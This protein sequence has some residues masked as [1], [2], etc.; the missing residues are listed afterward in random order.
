[1][2]MLNLS[3]LVLGCSLPL[4]AAL[5]EPQVLSF[6][7]SS[8]WDVRETSQRPWQSVDSDGYIISSR[9]RNH[10]LPLLLDSKDNVAIHIAARTFANDVYRVTGVRPEMYND[11]LPN[12]TR[13]AI[14]IGT[15]GS[16]LIGNVRGAGIPEGQWESYDARVVLDPVE[17]MDRALVIV[18]SDR[19]GTIYALYTIS[20]Q[21]GVSPFHFWADVP[22]KQHHTVAFS[23]QLHL[24][25][26][27]PTVKYRGTFIND[28][29]PALWGW[30]QQYYKREIW[31]AAF[32]TD[33]Y[34]PWFEMMLRL[35]A[36]YFWPASKLLLVQNIC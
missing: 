31:E 10:A 27:E 28:E 16:G 23:S 6:P 5:G 2:R 24:S 34:E 17:S 21:M 35:K 13:D 32:Q 20:E 22:I 18:G 14:I 19:R 7:I 8:S 9:H 26:G 1:M 33:F 4:T 29:H 36:N 25:H 15:Q 12:G 11:T 30:A 3:V